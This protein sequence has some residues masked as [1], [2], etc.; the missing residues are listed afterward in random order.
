MDAQ[1]TCHQNLF[2]LL[3]PA[4]QNDSLIQA[5]DEL[6]LLAE[7]KDILEELGMI[8]DVNRQQREVM[9]KLNMSLSNR[10]KRSTDYLEHKPRMRLDIL[11]DIQEKARFAYKEIIHLVDIKQKQTNFLQAEATKLL[12]NS[13]NT[14]LKSNNQLLDSSQKQLSTNNQILEQTKGMMEEAKRSGETIMTVS[15]C[16]KSTVTS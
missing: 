16:H 10:E 8:S 2:A 4:Q 1:M 12:L 3:S 5:S 6:R 15:Y 11:T 14:L 13:I 7:A 9:N